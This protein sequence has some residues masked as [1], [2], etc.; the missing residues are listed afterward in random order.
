MGGDVDRAFRL[1]EDMRA[2]AVL[3]EAW[4][5]NALIHGCFKVDK[6]P[7]RAFELFEQMRTAGVDPNQYTYRYMVYVCDKHQQ[8]DTRARLLREMIEK[9]Y[10]MPGEGIPGE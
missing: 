4:T 10:A 3:K 1:V 7:D 2:A 8:E 9:G 6:R 5:Y